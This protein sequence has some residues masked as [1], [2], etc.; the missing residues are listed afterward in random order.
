[1]MKAA[2]EA[3]GIDATYLP[4]SVDSLDFERR[5]A[6]LKGEEVT[7]MNVTMPYKERAAALVDSLDGVASLIGAIN[8]VKRTRGEYEGFNT[9]VVGIVRALG[10]TFPGRRFIS[11]VLVGAGGTARAFVAAMN[12]LAC[13]E[14]LVLARDPSKAARFCDSMAKAF[15][16][17]VFSH[18]SLVGVTCFPFVPDV[19]FNATPLSPASPPLE[20]V[21]A[22]SGGRTVVFDAVYSPAWTDLLARACAL[23]CPV[24]HGHQMLLEQGGAAFEL[25][26]G[27]KAPLEAMLRALLSCLGV[28][29]R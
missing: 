15:P 10:S 5:F 3:T 26:T 14:I 25:W 24:V 20:A 16:S 1:M 11:A 12:E 17:T 9:D 21:L 23:G 4:V 29:N 8:T 6:E 18:S 7:G 27:R 22:S 13:R 19:V 2:F 28:S